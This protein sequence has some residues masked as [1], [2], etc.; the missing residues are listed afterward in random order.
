MC[1]S[2]FKLRHHFFKTH[3]SY[4]FE[5][6]SHKCSE[7]NLYIF[8]FLLNF[9]PSHYLARNKTSGPREKTMSMCGQ[10]L[11]QVLS[12]FS[13]ASLSQ[14]HLIVRLV[15][16]RNYLHCCSL[17]WEIKIALISSGFSS[18]SETTVSVLSCK[19]QEQTVMD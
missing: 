12:T 18:N 11:R 4:I 17:G 7:K 2:F 3:F 1:K 13:V 8:Q 19:H 16:G 15:S 14:G 6:L 5:D 10:Y 9:Y